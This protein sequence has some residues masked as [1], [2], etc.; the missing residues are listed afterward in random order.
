MVLL[1]VLTD[2]MIRLFVRRRRL[3]LREEDG[4]K[5]WRI[6][7]GLVKKNPSGWVFGSGVTYAD[8]NIYVAVKY[9]TKRFPTFEEKFPNVADV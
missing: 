4:P 9:I 2:Y 7:E 3:K 5:Y 6:L 1:D 8:I